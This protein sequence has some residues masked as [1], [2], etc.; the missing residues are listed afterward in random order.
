MDHR[1]SIASFIPLFI[2]TIPIVT[3]NIFISKRKGKNPFIYGLL[4]L[5]PPV[6]MVY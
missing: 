5:I 4:S 6:V 1:G 3:M 2:M